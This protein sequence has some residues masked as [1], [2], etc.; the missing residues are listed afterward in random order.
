MFS[1]KWPLFATNNIPKIFQ[2]RNNT[3]ILHT[4]IIIWKTES[5][6]FGS[7]PVIIIISGQFHQYFLFFFNLDW[8]NSSRETPSLI[9]MRI[10]SAYILLNL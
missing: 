9:S 8:E 7:N 10:S 1:L 5:I 4:K 2:N 3:K 6:R